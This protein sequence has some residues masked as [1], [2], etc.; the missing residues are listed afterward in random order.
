V[1]PDEAN[2]CLRTESAHRRTRLRNLTH[3][4]R[5]SALDILAAAWPGPADDLLARMDAL[6]DQ[7]VRLDGSMHDPRPAP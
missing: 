4:E 6:R 2:A 1:T 7:P 3:S 5:T